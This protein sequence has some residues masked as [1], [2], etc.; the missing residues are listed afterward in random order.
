M[1]LHWKGKLNSLTKLQEIPNRLEL[2]E[3]VLLDSAVETFTTGLQV[4]YEQNEYR[5]Y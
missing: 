2:L 5:S 3:E 1:Q 4:N